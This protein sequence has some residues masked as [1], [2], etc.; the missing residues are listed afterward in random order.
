MLSYDE[1]LDWGAD[2]HYNAWL[3]DCGFNPENAVTWSE[4][5]SDTISTAAVIY[6]Q[7]KFDLNLAFKTR[8]SELYGNPLRKTSGTRN[9]SGW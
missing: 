6:N 8:L 5:S 2:Q 1:F 4:L 9:P 3:N 7:T